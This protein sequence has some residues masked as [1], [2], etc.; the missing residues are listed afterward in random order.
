MPKFDIKPEPTAA[1]MKTFASR[2]EGD[3]YQRC[4]QHQAFVDAMTTNLALAEHI[5]TKILAGKYN[6]EKP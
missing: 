6:G 1:E 2:F 4:C 3:E 5:A